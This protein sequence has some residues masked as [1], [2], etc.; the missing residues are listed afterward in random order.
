M[1]IGHKLATHVAFEDRAYAAVLT[2]DLL[3]S[4]GTVAALQ[5]HAVDGIQLVLTAAL[6]FGEEPLFEHLKQL[7]IPA[8]DSRFDDQARSLVVT[9]RQLV[10]AGIRSFHSETLSYEWE[11]P[12]FA[13][14]PVAVWWRVPDEDGIIV[15]SLSWMPLL[16]DYDAV[17]HHDTM[18]MDDCSIDG[19]YIHRN[20]G[21]N[22][23]VYA[24]QDSDEM[25]V[26]SWGALDASA[27]SL[28]PKPAFKN[29]LW[30]GWE[31]QMVLYNELFHQH[32][33]PLKREMFNKPVFWHARNI[34]D[35]WKIIEKKAAKVVHKTRCAG[36]I[37]KALF[38][39][40]PKWRYLIRRHKEGL[41]SYLKATFLY[42]Y[43][44]R[45]HVWNLV[46][47]AIR[48]DALAK[49]RIKRSLRLFAAYLIGDPNKK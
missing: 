48:G 6:R 39:I 8:P 49:D 16:V 27:V 46:K 10:S 45:R 25:M 13:S 5:K 1:G 41:S 32:T 42:Y 23:R 47:Q 19:D 15:H 7:G 28:E 24:V 30:G 36:P 43:G 33:D 14:S 31:K 12:Y 21:L 2:P 3:V 20:F 18:G 40:I 35:R 37:R 4:D 22:G 11:T 34:N 44:N 17:E 26:V 9:G 29:I 38:T